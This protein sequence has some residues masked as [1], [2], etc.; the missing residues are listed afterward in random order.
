MGTTLPGARWGT[1]AAWDGHSAYIFGGSDCSASGCFSRSEILRYNPA[2]DS[3]TVMGGTLPTPSESTSA[4]WDGQNFYIFGGERCNILP[5]GGSCLFLNQIVRYDPQSDAAVWVNTLPTQRAATSAIWD[6]RNAYVF[7]GDYQKNEIVQ[8]T[9]STNTVRVMGATLPTSRS[10]TSAI[11]DG[12]YAYVF[13]DTGS[14]S[15]NQVVRYDTTADAVS[16]VNAAFPTPFDRSSAIWTGQEAFIFG[17]EYGSGLDQIV[18]FDP[19]SGAVSAMPARLPSPRS[20]TSAVWD[21]S[22][23]YVFGGGIPSNQVV[24]YSPY[25]PGAP[26]NLTAAAG[27]NA[28]QVILAWQAPGGS[29]S[30][31][32]TNYTVYGSGTSNG[33]YGLLAALGNVATYTDTGLGN[34]VARF[35][36]VAAVSAAGEGVWSNE[37]NATTFSPPSAPQNLV[38]SAQIN[39]VR[40][41]WN[42]PAASGGSPVTEYAIYRGR[43]AGH[44]TWLA[45]V[46][47]VLSYQDDSAQG[48]TRY[49]YR[50]VAINAAGPG[51]IGN[52]VSARPYGR[53]LQTG[54]IPLL[55]GGSV[56]T[57]MVCDA[58]SPQGCQVPGTAFFCAQVS[59]ADGP[60]VPLAC[61]AGNA[62]PAQAKALLES[63]S[64]VQVR[65]P[66]VAAP[67]IT[68]AYLYERSALAPWETRPLC[69]PVSATPGAF[70]WWTSSG[71]DTALEIRVKGT[72]P[73][74]NPVDVAQSIP[75]LGQLVAATQAMRGVIECG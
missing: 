26:Q 62:V 17:G 37:A 74:G 47:D 57:I 52:E 2:T 69:D 34:S 19:A 27:P 23:A 35:Y 50:A 68:V 36:R 30:L 60:A 25:S 39:A 15:T 16:G 1:S 4:I 58:G 48:G 20:L 28:G 41:A 40:L 32:V 22:N 8:Y 55:P 31:P 13:G 44:E 65:L 38:A 53:L 10:G 56:A 66:T 54:S 21:G 18:R 42:A 51:P 9:P 29:G 33:P 3:M 75:Y 59:I 73:G 6:G 5:S 70:A 45:N 7:G 46:G 12:H 67:A 43:Q 14:A 72:G 49:H 63:I 11:W 24:R 61:V 71:A 64:P